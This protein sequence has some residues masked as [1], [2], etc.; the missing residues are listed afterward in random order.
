MQDKLITDQIRENFSNMTDD[1]IINFANEH[2][3]TLSSDGFLILREELN[4]RNIGSDIIKELEHEII[5]QQSLQVKK[6]EEDIHRNL[7][8][9]AWECAFIA[10]E[11]GESDYEIFNKLLELDVKDDYA[12]YIVRNIKGQA[13]VLKKDATT[14]IQAGIGIF[15]IGLLL[16][17]VATS[18]DRFQIPAGMVPI[19]G[20]IRIFL[21][22]RKVDRFKK[23]IASYNSTD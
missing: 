4:R 9:K 21:Y 12:H 3:R 2:G 20:I 1:Q 6:F 23:I 14:E 13:E 5:L 22:L 7:F 19:L 18:I 17:Y 11:K 15:L 16:L 8:V 10:R